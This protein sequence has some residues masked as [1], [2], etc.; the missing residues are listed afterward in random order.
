MNIRYVGLAL[1]LGSSVTFA[2]ETV[3]EQSDTRVNAESVREAALP[4]ALSPTLDLSDALAEQLDRQLA[5]SATEQPL[6]KVQRVSA[7][8]SPGS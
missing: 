3:R 6:P 7:N 5:E 2:T 8:L 1:L 4:G